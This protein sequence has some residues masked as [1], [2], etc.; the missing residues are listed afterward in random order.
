MFLSLANSE[1]KF[2]SSFSDFKWSGRSSQA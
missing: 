1:T 2:L